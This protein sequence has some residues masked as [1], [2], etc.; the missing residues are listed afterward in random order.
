M[1]KAATALFLAALS[2]LYAAMP[3][4]SGNALAQGR[5]SS[6]T[7]TCQAA[8]ALVRARGALTVGTG[9]DTFDRAVRDQSFCPQGMRTKPFFAPTLDNPNCLIGDRCFDYSLEPR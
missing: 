7:M 8:Q 6:T 2:T 9:G 1:R 5:P 4:T 3:G